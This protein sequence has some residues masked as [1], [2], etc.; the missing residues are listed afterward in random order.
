MADKIVVHMDTLHP[1]VLRI[2]EMVADVFGIKT[3]K[4][5]GEIALHRG[6]NEVDADLW[7]RWLDG[8]KE[9]PL[10]KGRLIIQEADPDQQEN[11][12]DEAKAG[13]P[14]GPVGTHAEQGEVR[15]GGVEATDESS[16]P[17]LPTTFWP[18]DGPVRLG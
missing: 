6:R 15:D 1:L 9:N 13:H 5:V 14:G 3:A 17:A 11:P 16:A 10:M 2:D 18:S 12:D 7:R 8:N 4:Q